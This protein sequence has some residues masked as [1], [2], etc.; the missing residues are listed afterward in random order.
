MY[1]LI[2]Q[3]KL[4]GVGLFALFMNKMS[5]NFPRSKPIND[6]GLLCKEYKNCK[7]TSIKDLRKTSVVCVFVIK[8]NS[9]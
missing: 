4:N 2:R 9:P 5:Y 8:L 6:V 1:I 3:N 7:V